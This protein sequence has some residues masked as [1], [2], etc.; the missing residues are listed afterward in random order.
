M[1]PEEIDASDPTETILATEPI[2]VSRREAHFDRACDEAYRMAVS[3]FSIDD[4]G[5]S[6]RVA[7]WERSACSIRVTFQSY[8]C[9]GSMGGIEHT[10]QFKAEA[11]KCVEDDEADTRSLP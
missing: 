8:E 9:S 2:V 1:T 5:H 11:V 4:Y 7:G 3:L 10:Y 6:R